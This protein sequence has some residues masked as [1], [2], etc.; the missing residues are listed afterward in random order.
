M[1]FLLEILPIAK[2][3]YKIFQKKKSTSV[4]KCLITIDNGVQDSHFFGVPN[5]DLT[6][7]FNYILNHHSIGQ[8][9]IVSSIKT[10]ISEIQ[11]LIKFVT[12]QKLFFLYSTIITLYTQYPVLWF[13][14]ILCLPYCVSHWLSNIKSY[15]PPER[16]LYISLH[17]NKMN[18]LHGEGGYMWRYD[19]KTDTNIK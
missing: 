12:K 4:I 8:I 10:H 6:D 1:F 15:T 13:P 11:S 9:W 2:I 7:D 3:Y 5:F 19:T 18:F 14:E 17:C 16:A